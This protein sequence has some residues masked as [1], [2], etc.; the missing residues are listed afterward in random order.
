MFG[1]L[2]EDKKKVNM[3]LDDL[4]LILAN[5]IIFFFYEN[6]ANEV[7]SSYQ[8]DCLE[9]KNKKTRSI[10]YIL[11]WGMAVN[12]SRNLNVVKCR[13]SETSEEKFFKV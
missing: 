5:I 6:D 12:C 4:L 9:K 1:P 13:V 3:T 8:D 2:Y 11:N 10:F 7:K